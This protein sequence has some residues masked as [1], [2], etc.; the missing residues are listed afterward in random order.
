MLKINNIFL[1]FLW[2]FWRLIINFSNFSYWALFFVDEISL[3]FC[4]FRL[5]I[6]MCTIIIFIK[7]NKLNV[8]FIILSVVLLLSFMSSSILM[9]FIIFELSIIPIFIIIFYEGKQY[10]RIIARVYLILYTLFASFPLLLYI[11]FYEYRGMTWMIGELKHTRNL[12]SV[13][14]YLS[15][16]AFL[17]KL[18]VFILHVWLPK[19]HVEAPVY[20]SIILAGVILKLGS[21]GIIKFLNF[22]FSH[23][24]WIDFVINF[25]IFTAIL[26]GFICLFSS[27]IKVL[28]ALSSVRHITLLAAACLVTNIESYFSVILCSISHGYISSNIFFIL[29]CLYERAKTRR[30]Y[31]SKSSRVVAL[32][33]WLLIVIISNFSAPPFLRFFAEILF[34][35]SFLTYTIFFFIPILCFIMLSTLYSLYI[36]Y[37]VKSFSS[38]SYLAKPL[39]IKEWMI[40]IFFLINSLFTI[41]IL[42]IVVIL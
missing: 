26:T 9:F 30:V 27:D 23:L 15:F 2:G 21:Y 7:N 6:S 32:N 39:E 12:I 5:L 4:L 1:Y 18:P 35:I 3:I 38:L 40:L 8:Y 10:E 42:N 41:R 29:N 20:G 14:Y 25:F 16:I 36:F 37:S 22:Q 33:P 13:F 17:T 11:I 31:I 28:I 24:L 34:V 19:A